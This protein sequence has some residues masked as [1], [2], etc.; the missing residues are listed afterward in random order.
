MS[1]IYHV[2]IHVN[3]IVPLSSLYCFATEDP[4]QFIIRIQVFALYSQYVFLG[5]SIDPLGFQNLITATWYRLPKQFIHL[6]YA[7][8]DL[9]YVFTA[10]CIV[11]LLTFDSVILQLLVLS[12]PFP[13]L[14]II[15]ICIVCN[16]VVVLL[17][18]IG[19]LIL[20]RVLIQLW[21]QLIVN[22]IV[23]QKEMK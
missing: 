18:V 16:Q 23:I 21:A 14:H 5:Y 4:F 6:P 9:I 8:I 2:N 13:V 17:P 22:V 1:A 12:L 11:L 3:V 7:S 19:I 10:F 15:M 20:I